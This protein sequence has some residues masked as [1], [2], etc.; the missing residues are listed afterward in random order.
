VALVE[1]IGAVAIY[2]PPYPDIIPIEE[3]FFN[4]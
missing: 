2:L 1:E 4:R 3:V